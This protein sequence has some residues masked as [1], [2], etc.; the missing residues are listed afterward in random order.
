VTGAGTPQTRTFFVIGRFSSIGGLSRF[1]AA[2]VDAAGN[3]L[4]DPSWNARVSGVYRLGPPPWADALVV[5]SGG[6]FVGGGFQK[7]GDSLSLGLAKLDL[8]TG[9]RY[10]SYPAEVTLPGSVNAIVR[11]SDGK[12]ILGGDFLRAGGVTRSHLARLDRDG[13]LDLSWSPTPSGGAVNALA[14]AG[15]DIFVGGY[16][17]GVGG[18]DRPYLVKLTA[19]WAQPARV[20]PHA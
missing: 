19:D 20:G 9:D 3:G 8:A 5:D 18:E 13:T 15:T 6:V 1:T 12:V 11:Q 2:K 10:A 16:F 4:A 14:I 17:D 7:A